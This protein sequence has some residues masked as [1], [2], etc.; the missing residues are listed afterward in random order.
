MS[1][2]DIVFEKYI[3]N[4]KMWWIF[5]KISTCTYILPLLLDLKLETEYYFSCLEPELVFLE[6]FVV[7]LQR[8]HLL[9]HPKNISY[10]WI[11]SFQFWTCDVVTHLKIFKMS[12]VIKLTACPCICAI[13]W[14]LIAFNSSSSILLLCEINRNSFSGVLFFISWKNSR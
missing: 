2:Y 14:A 13:R 11:L 5:W 7:G 3:K 8:L 12:T 6:L 9:D 4:F 10:I 1:S